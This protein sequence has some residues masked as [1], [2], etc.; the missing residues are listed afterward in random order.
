MNSQP[1]L[2]IPS[3][4]FTNYSSFLDTPC[5]VGAP[6]SGAP[7]WGLVKDESDGI[8]GLKKSFGGISGRT[9]G[10]SGFGGISGKCEIYHRRELPSKRIHISNLKYD[11]TNEIRV[12]TFHV[13]CRS[14]KFS[15]EKG[16]GIILYRY[17]NKDEWRLNGIKCKSGV[18]FYKTETALKN[19]K[20]G[21]MHDKVWN[22]VFGEEGSRSLAVG[23]GFAYNGV[24]ITNRSGTF[25]STEDIFHFGSQSEREL[26]PL[27]L[28]WI[29]KAMNNW[30]KGIQNTKVKGNSNGNLIIHPKYKI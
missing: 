29:T 22:S 26:N 4:K 8:S 2:K 15:N 7:I 28:K 23:G 14:S 19:V 20:G 16:L 27:E 3:P 24:K 25:N 1:T 11:F 18:I 13:C 5:T 9:D 17:N 6:I 10:I 30:K 12:S 21:T